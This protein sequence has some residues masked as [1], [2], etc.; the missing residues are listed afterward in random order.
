MWSPK[1]F[2]GSKSARDATG[3]TKRRRR[4]ARRI[5]TSCRLQFARRRAN[6]KPGRCGR[7]FGAL[8][9]LAKDRNR[10][11]R[12]NSAKPEALRKADS[13]ARLQDKSSARRI[14]AG[15]VT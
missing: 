5:E 1:I 4:E 8:S 2:A 11:I 9:E 14:L 3:N 13:N 15:C 12:R 7:K 10:G 6:R